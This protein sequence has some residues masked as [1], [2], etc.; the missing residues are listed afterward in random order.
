M[1][2][3]KE[4][5]TAWAISANPTEGQAKVAAKRLSICN[6]CENKLKNRFGVTVCIECGCVLSKKAFSPKENPCPLKKWD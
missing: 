2:D 1:V 6:S 4:I 3:V 5:L